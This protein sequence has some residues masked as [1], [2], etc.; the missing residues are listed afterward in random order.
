[1]SL[2]KNAIVHVHSL[3]QKAMIPTIS[4]QGRMFSSAT[5]VDDPAS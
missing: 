1:M 4:L 2:R 3:A 5:M